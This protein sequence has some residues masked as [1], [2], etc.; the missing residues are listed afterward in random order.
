MVLTPAIAPAFKFP[1]NIIDASISTISSFDKTEP[2]PALN[3]S[4]FSSTLI[5][6]STA[7][8][9]EPPSSSILYPMFK[10]SFNF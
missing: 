7:S 8:T 9:L 3:N 10:A 6:D 5:V 1:P 2:L 4:E